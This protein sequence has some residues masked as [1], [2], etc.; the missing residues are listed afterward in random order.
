MSATQMHVL[1]Q[2]NSK[3]QQ[4]NRQKLSEVRKGKVSIKGNHK[5]LKCLQ[6]PEENLLGMLEH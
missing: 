1:P 5:K 3:T 4:G 2:C 6:E